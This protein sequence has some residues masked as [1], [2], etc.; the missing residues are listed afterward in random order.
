MEHTFLV[1]KSPIVKALAEARGIEVLDL[2]M[3]TDKLAGYKGWLVLE[4]EHVSPLNPSIPT[5]LIP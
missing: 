1:R 5:T 2:K 4:D 3:S